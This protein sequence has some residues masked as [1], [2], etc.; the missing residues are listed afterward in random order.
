MATG[1]VKDE[2]SLV[3]IALAPDG[4]VVPDLAARLPGRGAWVS[5]DR[6]SVERAV[7]RK[8]FNRAFGAPVTVP[9]DLAGTIEAQLVQRALNLMGLARR[10][11]EFAA[12]QDAVRLALKAARP[13]WR[14]EA[15]DGASDGRSKIDRLARAA[16]GDIPVAGCFSAEEIGQAL[17]RGPVVHAAMSE[18]P[19]ARAFSAVMGKLAGFRP[20]DPQGAGFAADAK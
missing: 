15:S 13:A 17:G 14:I 6:A 2:A 18:G 11:G 3:R 1:D 20:L 12:G 10:A 5:A 7:A 16:W 8:A 9:A 19:Q 4:S